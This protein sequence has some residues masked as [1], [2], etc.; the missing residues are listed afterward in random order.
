[1]LRFGMAFLRL[2]TFHLKAISRELL[3]F[4]FSIQPINLMSLLEGKKFLITGISS[5]RS[6][7]YGIAKAC[8]REGAAVALSYNNE[9]FKERV[10]GFADELNAGEVIKLDA[11]D[12][13]SIDSA[14]NQLEKRWCDGFD[15]FVHSIGWAPREAIS[16]SFLEG[17]SRE[18][19]LQAMNISVYSY[20]A[21]AKRMTP[22]MEGHKAS[23]LTLSY[24]GAEKVVPNYNTMGL[25]KAALEAATRYIAAD[26]GPKQI[27][28]NSLSCGPIKTLAASGIKDF[29]SMLAQ[30]KAVSPLRSLVSIDEVGNTASFLLSD[31]SFG[32]TGETLYIDG[33]FNTLAC[34]TPSEAAK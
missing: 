33:G 20:I 5:N 23:I 16:G 22:L 34:C 29:S 12:D 1:M 13:A 18:G 3:K 9:R 2:L 25:C 28:A 4:C 26:V 31:Y 32:V 15:G 30:C 11:S 6:I 10:Q 19:F 14:A 17:A 27:R 21:L 8:V 24:L 7:A